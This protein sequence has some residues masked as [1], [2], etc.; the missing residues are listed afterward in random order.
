MAL[1]E[2]EWKQVEKYIHSAIPYPK[3]AART[4]VKAIKDG[5]TAAV[6]EPVPDDGREDALVASI[7]T[8]KDDIRSLK[9]SVAYLKGALKQQS[10]E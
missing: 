9:G 8:L 2:K 4:V 5:A 1:T 6:V 10:A 7:E 3:A